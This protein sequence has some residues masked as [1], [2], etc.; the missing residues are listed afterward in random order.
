MYQTSE[1]LSS[2][3]TKRK[4]LRQPDGQQNSLQ[5]FL[6]LFKYDLI[7]NKLSFSNEKKQCI[8]N[9]LYDKDINIV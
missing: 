7:I 2:A 9:N 4:Q 8:F 6:K 3:R 1:K 5:I